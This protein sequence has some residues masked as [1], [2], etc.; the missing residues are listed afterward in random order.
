MFPG[1]RSAR[2]ATL[3]S[4]CSILLSTVSVAV[5]EAAEAPDA[6][7]KPLFNGRDLRG[8][9]NVN[10]APETF[11]VRDGMIHCDG[12][13]TGALRTER[14]YENFILELEW[15]HLKAGGNAGVFIWSGPM[16][17]LGQPF[18]R[19]IEVQV[20][21]HG[22]GKSDWFTTHGDIFPIH[23]SSMKPFAPSRGDRSFPKESR[24]LGAPEW[25]HYRIVATNG[26]IRLS[27]NGAEVSGG[28]D[29]HWRRGY[30]ALES[31]GGIVDWRNLRIRELP[32]ARIAASESA[33]EAQPW[34][35]LYDGRTLRGWRVPASPEAWKASDWTLRSRP[36]G[37]Q[38]GSVLWSEARFQRD[39]LMFDWRWDGKT[40]D[41][42]PPVVFRSRDG[43]T[44]FR[45]PEMAAVRSEGW[46]R[47]RVRRSG[48]AL[49]VSAND[50]DEVSVEVPRGRLEFGFMPAS[51]PLQI[52]SVFRR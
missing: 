30:I 46:N 1:L 36:G 49:K 52:S 35:S 51:V 24:S 45:M 40:T 50:A 7:F 2:A 9:V 11:T 28:T 18:L 43:G 27:V 6:G 42:V 12:V 34:K 5:V 37:G 22:Y 29:C 20:L 38:E 31:E 33:P 16:P 26:V 23:G 14:Q 32:S 10:C 39:E 19:A 4:L 44:I 25:N 47:L 21:D 41:R 3:S 17:A 48:S 13:P 8:W 15:R